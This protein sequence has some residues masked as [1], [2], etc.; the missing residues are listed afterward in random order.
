MGA[1]LL[2]WMVE[3]PLD[4]RQAEVIG[5]VLLICPDLVEVMIGGNSRIG[6]AGLRA[7]SAARIAV[8][9]AKNRSPTVA[10]VQAMFRSAKRSSRA[11]MTSRTPRILAP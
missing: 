10:Q 5:V 11:G 7:G 6:V 9:V 3:N 4:E 1:D 2:G 8:F